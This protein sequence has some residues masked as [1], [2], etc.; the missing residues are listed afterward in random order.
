MRDPRA[1]HRGGER[2]K[3]DD[4]GAVRRGNV[5]HRPGGKQRETD[6]D[7]TGDQREARHSARPGQ[8]RAARQDDGRQH[9][10]DD[11]AAEADEHR[12]E[13]R[14]GEPSRGKGKAE[15]RDADKPQDITRAAR[16]R[17]GGRGAADGVLR[18]AS[19][20]VVVRQHFT[21]LSRAAARRHLRRLL[22][23]RGEARPK[24]QTNV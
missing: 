21:V 20:G 23:T 24:I 9:G 6:D 13:R 2:Q 7:A 11:G 18:A 19:H 17:N 8:G 4:D 15:A 12:I 16:A 10:R 3:S 1:G 14:D 22:T 5:A